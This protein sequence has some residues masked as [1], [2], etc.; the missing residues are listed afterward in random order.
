MLIVGEPYRCISHSRGVGCV[1]SDAVR[2]R[3]PC[4]VGAWL[5]DGF[6]RGN[7]PALNN[8]SKL[9]CAYAGV[10]QIVNPG[11]NTVMIP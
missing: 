6:D 3:D 1:D 9:M 4:T 7:M 8:T 2:S 10:I 11:Q 5:A